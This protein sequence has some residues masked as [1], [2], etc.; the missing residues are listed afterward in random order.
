MQKIGKIL[1]CVFVVLLILVLVVSSGAYLFV[2]RSFPTISGSLE[3]PGLYQPVTVIRDRWGV[4]HVYAEN[5][6]DLFLAQGYVHAQDRL[7]QMEF[8]RRIG[9][10]TLSE[11]LGDETIDEDK[12]LRTV[13]LR[14]AAEKD[15]E[16]LDAETRQSLQDYADG[17]NAFIASHRDRLPIEF[18][19]L[20]FEPATWTPIDSLTWGKVMCLDLGGNW[21]TELLRAKLIARVGAEKALDLLPAYPE[22]GPFIIPPE[23]RSYADL[24]N[25]SL[26]D[27]TVRLR[28]GVKTPGIGSN[29]WVVDGAKT[30]SGKP[31]LANDP[32]LGIQLP[33]IWYE[34][35]L[36]SGDLNLVG[37][38]FPGAPAVIIGHNDRIA[39]GVTNLGPDVQDLYME[40]LNPDNPR[41]YEFMGQWEEM[42]VFQEEIKVKGQESIVLEVRLTRHGPLLN[43]AVEGLEQPIALRWTALDA[44]S[45]FVGVMRINLA[46][47]WESFRDALRDWDAPSQNFVY[48]DVDGN[49]GY[50][51]PGRIP[52]RAKGDGTVPVPGWTGEYEWTGYIPFDELPYVYNPP[53]HFI[54]TANNKVVPDDYPYFLS[55]EWS[56]GYRAQRIIDLLTARMASGPLTPDDLRDIQADVYSL[57]GE[58]LTPYLL[59]ATPENDLQERALNQVRE[60]DRVNSAGSPGAAILAVFY[61]ELVRAIF[62]DEL[63]DELFEDYGGDIL[64]TEAVLVNAGDPWLDDVT[65]PA[66]ETRQEIVQRAFVETV[67]RLRDQLGNRPEKWTWGRLHTATFVHNPLGRSDISL[68]ERLVNKGPFPTGGSGYTVNN[69]GYDDEFNQEMV[70]S[71]R[72]IVDL[73]DWSNSRSQHTTGQSG[74]P[75]HEH[76]ADMI[77]AWQAVKHH[78]MLFDREQIETEQEGTL[79]LQ[80]AR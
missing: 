35:G 55:S 13:G 79:V 17:V 62:A 47:D 46:Q 28:L 36:H 25:P 40:K 43:D 50:Q 67:S 29:N 31:L 30:A 54:V 70:A 63:G 42:E 4:P 20:G 8:N 57:P 33:S 52:I 37:A 27:D 18:T 12:F 2:R 38:T 39:W 19:L 72:Q 5:N 49:I 51:S 59:E 24:G 48:A 23:A 1:G 15:W 53:T 21:E 14:R 75:M 16:V 60:W 76:Y 34:M 6:H 7:W 11:V 66:V 74:Q 56:P 65:T 9:R 69:A 3:V 32:H 45:L 78:P 26:P 61:Q 77:Q 44:M 10:G 22:S 68:L 41:Q 73:S 64:A 71:Y 80:P 58:F